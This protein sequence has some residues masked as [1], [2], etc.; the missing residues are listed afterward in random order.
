MINSRLFI[1][2]EFSLESASKHYVLAV[3]NWDLDATSQ[4]LKQGVDPYQKIFV[5]GPETAMTLAVGKNNLDFVE[6]LLQNGVDPNREDLDYELP[7]YI[8]VYREYD[9]MTSLLLKYGANPNSMDSKG[10]LPIQKVA[11]LGNIKLAKKL[12]DFGADVNQISPVHGCSLMSAVLGCKL[13]MVEFLCKNGAP[14]N[15]IFRIK[16]FK[17]AMIINRPFYNNHE[18][19]ISILLEFGLDPNYVDEDGYS[20]VLACCSSAE[21]KEALRIILDHTTPVRSL[22]FCCCAR[23]YAEEDNMWHDSNLCR[24]MF[25]EIMKHIENKAD[26]NQKHART[27]LSALSIAIRDRNIHGYVPLLSHGANPNEVDMYGTTPLYW[28]IQN[29]DFEAVKTLIQNKADPNQEFPSGTPLS[30]AFFSCK[31]SL[32]TIRMGIASFLIQNGA[33]IFRAK[34]IYSQNYSSEEFDMIWAR[35]P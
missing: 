34:E 23:E 2:L 24:D 29:G 19:V 11:S 15:T 16:S 13:N 28:A 12:I 9:E 20:L 1:F 26:V 32:T 14:P 22:E 5:F 4:F 27:G 30:E 25:Y 18:K 17:W 31:Y 33:D 6:M 35:F 3:N 8:S 21:N 10:C 7:L